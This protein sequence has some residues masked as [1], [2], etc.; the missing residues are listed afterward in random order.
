MTPIQKEKLKK[1]A[2][3]IDLKNGKENN[4]KKL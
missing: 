4:K 2:E 3:L 1:L